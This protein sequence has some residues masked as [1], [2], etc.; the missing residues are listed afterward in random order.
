V[1]KGTQYWIVATSD[2]TNA[3]DFEG[4]WQSSNHAETGADV[5]LGGWFSFSNNLPA[6]AAS[7]TI[8]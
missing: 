1:T 5:A 4:V 6:A 2:D 8:P 3:P 7:G